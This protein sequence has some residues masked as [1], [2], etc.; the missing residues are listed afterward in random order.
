MLMSLS[1]DRVALGFEIEP[2][3]AMAADCNDAG[4]VVPVNYLVHR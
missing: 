2:C 1:G 4:D 3:C